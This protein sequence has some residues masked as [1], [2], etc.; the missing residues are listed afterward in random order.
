MLALSAGLAIIPIVWQHHLLVLVVP[1]AVLRPRL[2]WV[3]FLMLPP[4][5][6]MISGYGML[7]NQVIPT[8]CAGVIV[9]AVAGPS[10][11]RGTVPQ[12]ATA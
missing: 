10:L 8:L 3:W 11:R 7:W 12:P 2:S 9:F 1:L 5:I 6:C 4:W